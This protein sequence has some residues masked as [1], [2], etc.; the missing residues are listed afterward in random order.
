MTATVLITGTSTGIGRACVERLACGGWTVFA[1][2]RR[3][4]DGEL[5]AERVPGDVRPLLLD[6]SDQAQIREAVEEVAGAVAGR[7]LDG[8]VNNAGI[9][10]AGPVELVPVA[11]WRRQFEVNLFGVVALTQAALVAVA[12]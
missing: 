8:L 3:R 1:G 9:G 10:V 5:L 11:D 12:W 4:E 7:G 6:V 2:V